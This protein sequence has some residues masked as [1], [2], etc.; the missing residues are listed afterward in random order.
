MHRLQTIMGFLL[1]TQT[2][3]HLFKWILNF[4]AVLYKHTRAV[5]T[6]AHNF[7]YF[8]FNIK[9]TESFGNLKFSAHEREREINTLKWLWFCA[10]DMKFSKRNE[11]KIWNIREARECRESMTNSHRQSSKSISVLKRWPMTVWHCIASTPSLHRIEFGVSS[12][13]AEWPVFVFNYAII[14]I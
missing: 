10:Y 2:N 6:H 7:N 3:C 13:P 8:Q 14:S 12:F 4:S 9:Y 5:H 1:C 11:N